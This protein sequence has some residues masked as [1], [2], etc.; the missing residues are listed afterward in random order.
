MPPLLPAPAVRPTDPVEL[1]CCAI[2]RQEGWFAGPNRPTELNNP[3]DLVFANQVNA[4]PVPTTSL[5]RF[6]SAQAGIIG[7]KRDVLALVAGGDT[8]RNIL[9]TW[10]DPRVDNVAV[11]TANVAEWTGL[12]LDVPVLELVPQLYKL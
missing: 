12:P 10:L 1:I 7:L 3:G 11:Y 9:A 4:S 6:S 2:A 5:A 8:L